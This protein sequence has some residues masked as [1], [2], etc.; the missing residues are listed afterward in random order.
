MRSFSRSVAQ[1]ILGQD[2]KSASLN[3]EGEGSDLQSNESCVYLVLKEELQLD[4]TSLV[5]TKLLHVQYLV[6]SSATCQHGQ[7]IL[8][9]CTHT[10]LCTWHEV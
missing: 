9:R 1:F 5:T 4:V 6:N 3:S 8:H 2:L 7:F 10:N